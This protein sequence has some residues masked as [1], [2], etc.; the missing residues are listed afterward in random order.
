MSTNDSVTQQASDSETRSTVTLQLQSVDGVDRVSPFQVK[1]W[2]DQASGDG[3]VKSATVLPA[4]G[5]NEEVG[6][7]Q[8]SY[9]PF[10]DDTRHVGEAESF[11]MRQTTEDGRKAIATLSN[12]TIVADDRSLDGV[13]TVQLKADVHVKLE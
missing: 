6:V 10:E 13:R 2:Y 9:V 4:A 5:W 7:D 11:T 1:R 3:K 8:A 12:I